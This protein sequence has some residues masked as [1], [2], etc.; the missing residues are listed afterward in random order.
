VLN[1]R[2][3]TAVLTAAAVLLAI[4]TAAQAAP[5]ASN[6]TGPGYALGRDGALC[7]SAQLAP[8]TSFSSWRRIG[9]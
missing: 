6:P 4:A 5:T 2:L 7:G 3:V 9:R 1:R 8:G